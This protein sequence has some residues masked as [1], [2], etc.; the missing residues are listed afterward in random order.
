MA[1]PLVIDKKKWFQQKEVFCV[2]W[3]ILVKIIWQCYAR[4][5]DNTHADKLMYISNDGT[6]NCPFDRLQLVV[7]TFIYSTW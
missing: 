3:I 4:A 7:E 1:K 2:V 6:Q 5:K